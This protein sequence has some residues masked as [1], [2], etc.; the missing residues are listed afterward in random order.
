MSAHRIHDEDLQ[1]S[2]A[3]P[4][5]RLCSSRGEAGFSDMT[6]EAP[7]KLEN[8]G[9]NRGRKLRYAITEIVVCAIT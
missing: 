9:A 6:A 4:L 3:C 1:V 2:L 8:C 5:K 7:R